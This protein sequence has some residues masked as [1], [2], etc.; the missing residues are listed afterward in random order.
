MTEVIGKPGPEGLALIEELVAFMT[1]DDFVYRHKWTKG[2]LL[3]WDN[4]CTLHTG[5]LYDDTKYYPD[6]AP[7]VGEGRQAL[8]MLAEVL[9]IPRRSE[10]ADL[11]PT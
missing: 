1:G 9:V 5:T 10:G 4:R 3:M 2:D 7:A 8:L 6:H 11:G